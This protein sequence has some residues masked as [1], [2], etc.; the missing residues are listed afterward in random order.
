[1]PTDI[2]TNTRP[3]DSSKPPFLAAAFD[4]GGARGLY[5]CSVLATVAQRFAGPGSTGI[6]YDVG[7]RFNLIAGVSTGAILAA[8]L[9]MGFSPDHLVR[10]YRERG[11]RIFPSPVPRGQ[12][13]MMAFAA[14]HFSRAFNPIAPLREALVEL[15]GSETFDSMHQARKIALCIPT[16]D[17]ST[18]RAWVYKTGHLPLKT[19]DNGTTLVDACLASSAALGV[20]TL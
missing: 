15:F 1:M 19:R 12:I 11:Q 2:V 8:A 17:V 16:V 14:R 10:L 6:E 9:A 7:A 5:S 18:H 20:S 4:G 13:A 3:Y